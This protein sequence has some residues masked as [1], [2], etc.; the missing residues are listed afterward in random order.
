MS[1]V[2]G[3]LVT[4]PDGDEAWEIEGIDQLKPFLVSVVNAS[5]HWLYISTAGGLTGGRVEAERA[6]FPYETDDRLHHAAGLTG[7]FTLIRLAD[8]RLWQP[9]DDRGLEPGGKRLLRKAAEGDWIEFE[10]QAHGLTFRYRWSISPTY[11]LVRRSTL[12]GSGQVEVLDGLLNLM[13]AEVSLLT[14]QGLSTLVDA[15]KRSELDPTGLGIFT[16]EAHLSDQAAPAEAL[17][18]NVVWRMGLPGASVHLTAEA[19]RAFRRGALA[20]PRSPVRGRRHAYLVHDTVALDHG[21]VEWSLV[22]EVHLDHVGV[23][24]LQRRLATPEGLPQA[25]ASD[26]ST[27]R[28]ALVGHVACADGLQL[29]ADRATAVHH[30]A[31]VVFNNLRGG[32]F[33]DDHRI[34]VAD[35][36][37][38]VRERNRAV[39][40]RQAAWL[41]GL[42][43]RIPHRE[44]LERAEGTGDLQL[45]RLCMEYLPLTLGRRHGDPSRPWNRFSIHLRHDD[46]STRYA[47][48]GNWR[49]IFQNWEALA[50]SFPGFLEAMVAK[51]VNASTIDGYN[52]YRITR[53][54]I[55]WEA[56]D[57]EDPWANIGYWGDHQIVYLFR[58]VAA[59]EA[60]R[61]ACVRRLLTRDLFSYGAVPYRIKPYEQLVR[62]AKDTIEF[63]HDA[64]HVAEERSRRLG[65]D[66]RLIL[67]DDEQVVHVNLLEKLLV[68]I[69]AK[70]SNFVPDG[71]IWLNTQRP[72]WNDANNALV[73]HG[74]SMV[75]LAHLRPALAE[76]RRLVE[77]LGDVPVSAPVVTWLQAV[78]RAFADAKPH[79]DTP[80]PLTP[81]ARRSVLDALGNAFSAYRATV[82]ASGMGSR[83]A[84]SCSTVAD[85]CQEALAW[86]DQS[87]RHNRREDG[88]FHSYNLLGLESGEAHVTPLYEMLEGQVAVLG[89][90]LLN[91]EEAVGLLD[92]LF[93]SRL[94]REDQHSF[95]LYPFRELPPYL[96]KNSVPAE[97]VARVPLLAALRDAGDPCIVARDE[98]GG[99]RF[100]ADLTNA[101]ALHAALDKLAMDARWTAAVAADRTAVADV[102]EAVFHHHAFTGRSGTM[103]KYE[104]L[105]SVYWHMVSKLLVSVQEAWWQATTP[106]PSEPCSSVWRRTTTMCGA[107]CRSTN[108][109]RNTARCPPTPTP[110]RP[111][112]LGAQ[113]PGMT[114]Q[115]KEEIITRL[116]EVGLRVREGELVVEPRLLRRRE[117]LD[118]PTR[119]SFVGP[120]QTPTELDVPSRS[121]AVTVAQVPVILTVGDT[122]TVE[123]VYADGRREPRA[124]NSL[125]PEASAALFARE[126]EIASVW[127]TVTEDDLWLS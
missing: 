23:T 24:A 42:P 116:G 99:F 22:G 47:Y 55:D 117:L 2:S 85:L 45:E 57:P 18:A 12:E 61:P 84:V 89:S 79:L 25:V 5:D 92:A 67:D 37:A 34:P 78:T 97:E 60:Y 76:L 105:G 62:D 111:R 19:V 63:D 94:Y 123:V 36:A 77:G 56:P 40:E 103:Y 30:F 32:V 35:L 65:S 110:I 66:G 46:G 49:D 100:Q 51:F 3:R 98:A 59:A 126:G 118:A 64:D 17:R 28:Q 119:W 109:S 101:D 87:L 104:G 114:G 6:L 15:Y 38:F 74:L 75:T 53:E 88:L 50:Q 48:E 13:P 58:L 108:R 71:G 106:A 41:A 70:L 122:S 90:G 95:L 86:L 82:Y 1:E 68:S 124:G 43:N 16:M 31:N 7:P 44:L 54:G 26:I 120:G 72:E 83:T 73:G 121:V 21:P 112:H 33:P 14:Q 102:Y 80:G 115:V 96:A 91:G 127:V 125:G 4:L 81:A 27:G 93:Q 20:A 39:H 8:G 52:P 69:L 11:G 10:E 29:T 113:Q 9:F 107:A